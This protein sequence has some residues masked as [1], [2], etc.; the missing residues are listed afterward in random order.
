MAD[1]A[2]PPSVPLP[3]APL[4]LR[5]AAWLIDA[6]LGLA[7]CFLLTRV[8]GGPAMVRTLEHLVTFKS[9]NGHE[10]HELS[11]AMTPGPHQLDALRGLTRLLVVLLVIGVGSVAYRV[12]TTAHWGAGVGKYLLGLR[13]AVRTPAGPQLQRPGFKRAWRRWAVPQ[14]PGLIP[15]PG[16]GLLAYLPAFRDPLR[17]GLHDRAAGTVVVDLAKPGGRRR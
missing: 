15:F 9:I 6:A 17:R 7:A 16:T 1:E 5:I 8:I 14:A 4:T 3:C 11:A 12:V 13:I 2:R 10:G